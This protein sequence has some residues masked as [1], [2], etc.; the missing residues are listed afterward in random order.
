MDF[1]IR[2]KLRDILT[3]LSGFKL[4]KILVIEFE[5]IDSDDAAK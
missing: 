2:T 3:K 1:A 5:N 4:I